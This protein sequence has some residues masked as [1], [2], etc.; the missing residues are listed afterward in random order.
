MVSNDD[1]NESIVHQMCNIDVEVDN[2]ITEDMTIEKIP[3]TK[4]GRTPGDST[5]I[6]QP[7]GTYDI[8]RSSKITLSE[9]TLC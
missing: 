9:D 6:F 2:L 7:T 5:T 8:Q 1:I 3:D 4:D